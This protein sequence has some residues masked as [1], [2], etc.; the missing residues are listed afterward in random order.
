M[1]VAAGASVTL[2]RRPVSLG[3]LRAGDGVAV[4]FHEDAR[5]RAIATGIAAIRRP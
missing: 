3:D 5:G 4:T 2:N 1:T